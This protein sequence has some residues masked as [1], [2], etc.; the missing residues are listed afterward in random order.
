MLTIDS[1]LD[2][3]CRI[4]RVK[5]QGPKDLKTFSVK[6]HLTTCK[7]PRCGTFHVKSHPWDA[8]LALFHR[9]IRC[10]IHKP[11]RQLAKACIIRLL[12]G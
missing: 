10:H 1:N 6:C 5:P 8:K 7:G 4:C 9:M 11:R 3:L 2:D 12:K